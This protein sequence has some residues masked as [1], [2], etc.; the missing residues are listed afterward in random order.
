MEMCGYIV[1]GNIIVILIEILCSSHTIIRL[2][3]NV[4]IKI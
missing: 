2:K 3:G 4:Q 1:T